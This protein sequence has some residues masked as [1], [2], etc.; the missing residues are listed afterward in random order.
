MLCGLYH[1]SVSEHR[2]PEQQIT[3]DSCCYGA[4]CI[5]NIL[6]SI[7]DAFTNV[8]ATHKVW[9]TAPPYYH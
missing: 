3:D 7:N 8:Q 1:S 4:M 2:L 5:L 9:T 6:F